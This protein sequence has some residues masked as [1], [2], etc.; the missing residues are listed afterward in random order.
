MPAKLYSDDGVFEWSSKFNPKQKEFILSKSKYTLGSGGYG[1]GK[2]TAL[3]VRCILMCIESPYFGDLSGNRILIG[4]TKLT[5]FEKTTYIELMKWLPQSW[6]HREYK[7]LGRLILTNGSI[8]DFTHLDDYEHLQ[9]YNAGHAFVDQSEQLDWKVFKALAYERTRLKTLSPYNAIGK[10][11]R[12]EREFFLQGVSMVCNPRRGWQYD[13][14]VLNEDYKESPDPVVFK[15]HNPRYKLITIPTLENTEH[16][17]QDY[18]ENQRADKSDKEFAR[19]VL[20]DWSKFE[21]QVY[22]DFNDDLINDKNIVPNMNWKFYVGIDHGGTGTPLANN[23]TGI[24][25]VPFVAV[26]NREGEFPLIHVFDELYLKASTIEQTV[27]EIDVRLKGIKTAQKYAFNDINNPEERIKVEQWRCDPSMCRHHTDSN[28]M[29]KI[30]ETYM[31]FAHSR[32]LNMPLCG[33]DN[34]II[35]GIHKINWLC[36]KGLLRINPRCINLI[37]ELRSVEYGNNEKPK[38]MQ[39]DHLVK[40]LQ[41]ICSAIPIWWRDYELTQERRSR[42]ERHIQRFLNEQNTESDPIFGGRYAISG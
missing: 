27:T 13:K 5:D 25:A 41:Y 12:E 34:D 40:A 37:N 7:K 16:L 19:D 36:R 1:S 2:S 35:S 20:G 32:G 14:F 3:V 9:S 10:P 18:I 38:A 11:V 30:S 21:G 4:R 24:T 22:E 29:E 8:I 31:K 6:I 26:E 15:K 23:A 33:G 28:S 42:E 17:P 39:A